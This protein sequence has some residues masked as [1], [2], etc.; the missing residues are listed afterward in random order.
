MGEAC[1]KSMISHTIPG[2]PAPLA[3]S[4]LGAL[5]HAGSLRVFKTS[6]A[7]NPLVTGWTPLLCLDTWEHAFY[8]DQKNNK[9]VRQEGAGI[10]LCQRSL[11]LLY[12]EP[13][14][15]LNLGG[16]VHAT[17]AGLR[18]WTPSCSTW[19]TGRPQPVDTRLRAAWRRGSSS[20]PQLAPPHVPSFVCRHL[21]VS[22][23]TTLCRW[24]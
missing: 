3:T 4:T 10:A 14:C 11:M 5:P 2:S 19:S 1:S 18:T 24:F 23:C 21:R 22:E 16:A 20:G 12:C 6:N 7:V 8:V 9:Y 13:W 17:H 15:L